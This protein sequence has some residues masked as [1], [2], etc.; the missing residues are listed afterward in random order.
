MGTAAVKACHI[1]RPALFRMATGEGEEFKNHTE[2]VQRYV[3]MHEG[4][5]ALW[6]KINELRS[7]LSEYEAVLK[8]LEPMESSRRCY[9][10]VGDVLVERTVGEV[11]PDVKQTEQ[12]LQTVSPLTAPS[13]H[14]I[15]DVTDRC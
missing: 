2:I 10:L 1:R 11:I 8:A 9:R 12:G 14:A 3:S 5:E 4:V 7:E 6:T 13:L 15:N